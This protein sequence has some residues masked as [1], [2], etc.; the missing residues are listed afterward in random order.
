MDCLSFRYTGRELDSETGL[1][2]YRARYYDPSTGRFLSEDPIRF[3]SAPNFYPYVHNRPTVLRDST[4][5]LAWGSGVGVAGMIGALMAGGGGDVSCLVV[6]D[7]QGNS[8]LLCC[9]GVGGG[10]VEGASLSVQAVSI[11]CPNCRTICDMEGTFVQVQGFGGLG[12]TG[13]GGLGASMSSTSVAVV[14]SGG[15][16]VGAGAGVVVLGGDCKLK[17]GGKTCKKC[18]S[19]K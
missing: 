8:G 10:V 13:A 1:Y 9:G 15:G 11:V 12:E 4:G 18:P 17:L 2:Y 14:A 5:L 19:Q 3:R 7:T 16:G 6:G